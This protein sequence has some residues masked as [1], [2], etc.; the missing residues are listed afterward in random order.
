MEE[1]SMSISLCPP[2]V[3]FGSRVIPSEKLLGN[4]NPLG[5]VDDLSTGFMNQGMELFKKGNKCAAKGKFLKMFNCKTLIKEDFEAV[6]KVLTAPMSD[7]PQIIMGMFPKK[8]LKQAKELGS[9]D[10]VIYERL[11]RLYF[12]KGSYDKAGLD[13]EKLVSLAPNSKSA[14]ELF[15]KIYRVYHSPITNNAI[16]ISLNLAKKPEYANSANQILLKEIKN[17]KVDLRH[18]G[19]LYYE[20]RITPTIG[21]QYFQIKPENR[22]AMAKHFYNTLQ[23]N[24]EEIYGKA[25]LDSPYILLE[26]KRTRPFV[27]ALAVMESSEKNN[28]KK[29]CNSYLSKLGL[30]GKEVIKKATI[31]RRKNRF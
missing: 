14:N 11:A 4:R 8:F 18:I 30:D 2:D 15:L 7:N 16:S 12:Q 17:S 1:C 29:L 20:N 21:K 3:R 6:A 31:V 24:I 19:Y 10:P 25:K 5:K 27:L 9:N 22:G 26:M 23:K 28:L 13:A